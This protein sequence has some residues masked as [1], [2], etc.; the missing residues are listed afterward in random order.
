MEL[1]FTF[2]IFLYLRLEGRG[3]RWHLLVAS[4][5][6]LWDNLKNILIRPKSIKFFCTE[7]LWQGVTFVENA[8]YFIEKPEECSVAEGHKRTSSFFKYC[9]I[10]DISFPT[11]ELLRSYVAILKNFRSIFH[12]AH[13][14]FFKL[15]HWAMCSLQNQVSSGKCTFV[16]IAGYFQISVLLIGSLRK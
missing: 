6:D 16:T 9:A 8:Q 15:Q 13:I 4:F 14:V 2:T 1:F 5:L 7:T 3:E 11:V 10:K 12:Q